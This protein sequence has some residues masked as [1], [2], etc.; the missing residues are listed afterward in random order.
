MPHPS[1]ARLEGYHPEEA[2]AHLAAIVESSD[3]AII[4][5]SL[6]GIIRS[7]NLGATRLYGYTAAETIGKPM[8][9]LLPVERANEEAEILERIAR[10]ERVEPF[11]TAHRCKTGGI[12]HVSLTISPILDRDGKVI[13]ASHVARDI[14]DRKRIDEQ[15]RHL[16]AIVQSS[17]DAIVSKTLDGVIL[18]WNRG[19][20]RLYGYPAGEAIG[21]SM[22]LLLPPDRLGEESAILDRIRHGEE[23]HYLETVRLTK[24]GER[25]DVSLTISPIRDKANRIIGASHVARNITERRRLEQRSEHLAA[26]VESAD[27]AIISKTLDGTILTWNRG[28]ERVYGY[29]PAEITGRPMT[30]LLPEDR[31]DEETEILQRIRR[32]D[33]VEHF[34]T[35]RK[36]KDGERIDVSLTIS[37]IRDSRGNITGASHVARN[38]TERK[39][40]EDQLRHT[41]K[42]ESLGVLAG[43]VAHDF[44][45]LLTGIMGNA[46]LA[47]ESVSSHH[48]ARGQLRDVVAASERASHLTRQLLAY[49]G[50]GRFIIEPVNLSVLVR[51]INH[52]IQTSIPKNVQLRLDLMN[53]VPLV[54]ADAGQLQQVVMNL[55]INGAEAVAPGENGTVLV[56]TGIRTLDEQYLLS[57]VGEAFDLK[58]GQYVM[59]EVHDTG[60][61]MDEATVSRI[62]DPFFTTKFMGRGLGLAAVQGIVRGHKGTM[63]V[64]S[65]PG[66]GTTFKVL[67]PASVQTVEPKKPPSLPLIA[68][69]ELILVVDD[70]EIVRRTAKSVLERHGYTVVVA[71]NG[72]EGLELFKVLSEKVSAVLLDMTMPVMG[73]EEAF[74]CMR[75]I[76]G[77]VKVILSSGYNEVE[78]VRRFTGKGLAGFIQKPYSSLALTEKIRSILDREDGPQGIS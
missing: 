23:V 1:D 76:R 64:Y 71:E 43:G 33:R 4:S 31:P 49:A 9:L 27:D 6:Q 39:Q 55:V 41:Q 72:E 69:D 44:N 52:L 32:G 78:A 57:T 28:A 74:S 60:C 50:K 15:A 35:V 58:P 61:G 70:E 53:E 45:N 38:V 40:L 21:R 26:I 19:A 34:E 48:P 68:R 24:N 30:I 22:M 66:K 11:E 20:E 56:S 42:L 46:S 63:K 8:T 36:R 25:I 2:L 51:E 18:T 54:D 3:D 16:A 77:D 37:P 14:T 47:L 29:N 59:L 65:R 13:G 62:F 67:F 7:W 10:G 5:K 12:I 73:G 75:A 17:E